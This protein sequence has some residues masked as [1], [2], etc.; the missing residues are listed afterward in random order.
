MGNICT[1]DHR[2]GTSSAVA[3]AKKE[4]TILRVGHISAIPESTEGYGVLSTI[5]PCSSLVKVTLNTAYLLKELLGNDVL[6]KVAYD[7]SQKNDIIKKLI[8]PL[9]GHFNVHLINAIYTREPKKYSVV[10]VDK[11]VLH[12]HETL[13]IPGAGAVAEYFADEENYLEKQAEV[14]GQ[15]GFFG[16]KIEEF[17]SHIGYGTEPGC[18]AIFKANRDGAGINS[19][20]DLHRRNEIQREKLHKMGAIRGK[21]P[22]IYDVYADGELKEQ[23]N[24]NYE[25]SLAVLRRLEAQGKLNK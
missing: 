18:A 11:R 15:N 6:F 21:C 12:T 14:I 17:R 24:A 1:L 4:L 23:Y 19:I 5:A 3:E 10:C 25:D 7:N 9:K 8:L 20:D 22:I 13:T 16:P 2:Q